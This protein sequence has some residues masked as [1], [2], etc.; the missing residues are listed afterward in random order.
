[1]PS[2]PRLHRSTRL[3]LACALAVLIPLA[4]LALGPYRALADGDPASDV[5]LG[6]DVFYP[7]Q[8]KVSPTL[9]AG[10]EK[11]LHAAARAAGLH[12]KVAIIGTAEELGLVPNLFGHPQAYAR[13]LDREISFNQPQQLLVVMPAGF[14]AMPARLAGALAR[15][16]VYKQQ[17]SDGLHALGDPRRCRVGPRSRPPDRHPATNAILIEQLA[18]RSSRVRPPRSPADSRRP[19]PDAMEQVTSRSAS[20]QGCRGLTR[21]RRR[22]STGADDVCPV[23]RILA[24]SGR[25]RAR[26]CVVSAAS[27]GSGPHG[28]AGTVALGAGD[29]GP[30]GG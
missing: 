6:Q 16:P 11:T 4:F 24:V 17:R 7:Y 10:L 9:E 8:P 27:I 25:V 2:I 14:G 23:P 1:M 20:S 18:P 29:A 12:L 22:H 21:T 15:V 3:R 28:G 13:F 30:A 19:G 5:L 26:S